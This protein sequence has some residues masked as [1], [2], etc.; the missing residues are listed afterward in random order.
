MHLVCAGNI[1]GTFIKLRRQKWENKSVK[2]GE[3][4]ES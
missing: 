1:M 4:G 2:L 3:K